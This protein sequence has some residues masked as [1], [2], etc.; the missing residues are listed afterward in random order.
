MKKNI[1]V[2]AVMLFIFT[3]ADCFSQSA[4][5]R[6]RELQGT[7]RVIEMADMDISEPPISDLL[8]FTW[9]F[10]GNEYWM[11]FTN[12]Q[13]GDTETDGGTFRV[14]DDSIIFTDYEGVVESAVFSIQ[15]NLLTINIEGVLVVCRRQ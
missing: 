10:T 7:W 14:V 15:R 8:V 2:I 12:Y 9:A 4:E 13:T 5:A 11:K 1:I 3:S 6:V